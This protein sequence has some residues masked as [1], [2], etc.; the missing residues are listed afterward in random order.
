MQ[1]KKFITNVLQ[2]HMVTAEIKIKMKLWRTSISSSVW[3]GGTY[4][5]MVCK[6]ILPLENNVAN[7]FCE[8]K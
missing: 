3:I 8:N 1:K 6:E 7:K 5:S 2:M 4:N